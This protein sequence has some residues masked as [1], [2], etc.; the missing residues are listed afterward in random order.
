MSVN[1]NH[2]YNWEGCVALWN[3][4]VKDHLLFGRIG[5]TD[6]ISVGQPVEVAIEI[7]KNGSCRTAWAQ[8]VSF[9]LSDRKFGPKMTIQWMDGSID[10]DISVFCIDNCLPKGTTSSLGILALCAAS[11]A[12][13]QC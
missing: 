4:S 6:K 8:I 9:D 7:F 1:Y 3:P 10:S 12:P 13:L 5:D 2:R 11:F